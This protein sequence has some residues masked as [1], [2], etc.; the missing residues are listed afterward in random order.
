MSQVNFVEQFNLFMQYARRNKLTSYE[1][2]F[3]LGL[4]HCANDLARQTENF[5]WPDDYFPV[6]NVELNGWTAFDERAIRNTRNSLRQKGL[7]DFQKGD[8]KKS[9]PMY[10]IFYLRRSGYKIEPNVRTDDMTDCENAGDHATGC[11]NAAG[12]RKKSTST[13]KTQPVELQP[14]AKTQAISTEE[15]TTG[16]EFAP[17]TV[18]DPVGDPVGDAVAIDCENAA[19]YYNNKLNVNS[20]VNTTASF[21]AELEPGERPGAKM[22]AVAANPEERTIEAP[23]DASAARP[24]ARAAERTEAVAA[25]AATRAPA[26]EPGPSSR[27]GENPELGKVMGYYMDHFAAI[28]SQLAISGLTDFTERLGAD[29]VQHAMEIA[30]SER[31]YSWS[32][33]RGILNRYVREG[34]NSMAAVVQSEQQF[35][36]GKAGR[37]GSQGQS[38]GRTRQYVTAAEYQPPKPQP[39]DYERLLKAVESI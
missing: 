2:I 29:V 33:L 22:Q 9:D 32:Y 6:S 17:D 16:R 23:A 27:F 11:E 7:L 39:G 15:S 18:P 5:E 38:A 37:R 19:E 1:R 25:A 36:D 4:F 3:Y 13:A 28:P 24:E 10:R 8:G 14:T 20:N 21:P 35:E 31:K 26:G 34:L 12:Q 30:V